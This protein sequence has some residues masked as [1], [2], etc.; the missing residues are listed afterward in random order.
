MTLVKLPNVEGVNVAVASPAAALVTLVV[1]AGVNGALAA[2][3]T[4]A[5]P[6]GTPPC[7]R[8]TVTGTPT[9]AV[10]DSGLAVTGTST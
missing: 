6:T 3:C 8:R 10:P 2:H 1:L 7:S 5:P 9:P 4:V